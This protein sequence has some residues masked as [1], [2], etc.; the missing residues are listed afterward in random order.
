MNFPR[1]H[2]GLALAALIV[3][4]GANATLAQSGPGPSPLPSP[5]VPAAAT[6]A[7]ADT[8]LTPAPLATASGGP[9][10]GRRSGNSTNPNT[11]PSPEDSDT[12]P[13][14]Q[15]SSLDGTWEVEMQPMSA[16]LA[17]YSHLQIVATNGVLSGTWLH[18]PG[19]TRSPLTGTFDGRLFSLQAKMA[20]GDTATFTG[21]VETFADMV[22]MYH[23]ND[24]DPGIAFTAQHRKKEK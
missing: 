13:P 8:S 21:Y 18:D 11:K 19:K 23:A 4:A 3:I 22:G 20:N 1:L 12:P 16:R 9:R 7:P 5:P 15:F 6:P 10:R 2:L 14:P 17:R 24:K